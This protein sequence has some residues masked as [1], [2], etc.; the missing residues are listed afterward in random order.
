MDHPLSLAC[1]LEI[2]SLWSVTSSIFLLHNTIY[3]FLLFRTF[4]ITSAKLMSPWHHQ[5]LTHK[6]WTKAVRGPP[7]SH[8]P[9]TIPP[10]GGNNSYFLWGAAAFYSWGCSF[11][12]WLWMH[13]RKGI[14]AWPSKTFHHLPLLGL[15]KGTFNF[16]PLTTSPGFSTTTPPIFCLKSRV[17]W[18]D[19][20]ENSASSER[21]TC[22]KLPPR[23][24]WRWDG[25]DI[26]NRN[27]SSR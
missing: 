17:F 3:Y 22:K 1:K 8:P 6:S 2:K 16:Q 15:V 10:S 18:Q 25:L 27:V 26:G 4:W 11:A 21:K 12:L 9:N 7:S 14:Q 20:K 23:A 13:D 19:S 5:H 24:T